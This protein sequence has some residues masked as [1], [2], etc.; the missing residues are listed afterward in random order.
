MKATLNSNIPVS[1]P[2][3]I[4]S[5]KTCSRLRRGAWNSNNPPPA[6]Q[7]R[8]LHGM[9]TRLAHVLSKDLWILGFNITK[10][11]NE[12]EPHCPWCSQRAMKY[13]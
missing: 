12:L 9:L 11:L 5:T 7:R 10:V 13:Q 1:N 3:I 8:G 6:R 2:I 4:I